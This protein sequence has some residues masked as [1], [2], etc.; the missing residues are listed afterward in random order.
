MLGELVHPRGR[1]L[2]PRLPSVPLPYLP[3][4]TGPTL[5]LAI[6]LSRKLALPPVTTFP[7]QTSDSLHQGGQALHT[8]KWSHATSKKLKSSHML[9]SMQNLYSMH[10]LYPGYCLPV[11]HVEK[12]TILASPSGGFVKNFL[13][14][15]MQEQ[16]KKKL[17]PGTTCKEW[18]HCR[19]T[20]DLRRRRAIKSKSE[21][22]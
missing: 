8:R 3:F 9:R 1:T 15:H 10:R 11:D 6:S 2:S 16:T 19:G 21:A 13:H 18:Q 12:K 4:S 14:L 22:A 20:G 17:P 7:W 5:R